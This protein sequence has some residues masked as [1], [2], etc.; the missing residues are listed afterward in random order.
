MDSSYV[1]YYWDLDYILCFS[2]RIESKVVYREKADERETGLFNRAYRSD[3][4][5]QGIATHF[6]DL[7]KAEEMAQKILLEKNQ[8]FD[9]M[10]NSKLGKTLWR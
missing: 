2:Y 1:T 10:L 5:T 6:A 8:K 9:R 3:C 4:E 7:R